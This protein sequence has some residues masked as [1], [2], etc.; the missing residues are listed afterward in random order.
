MAC[1][2]L[3]SVATLID[4]DPGIIERL[5]VPKRSLIVNVPI[6]M[7]SGA[8]PGNL[9]FTRKD[10]VEDKAVLMERSRE[11][12]AKGKQGLYEEYVSR[13]RKV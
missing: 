7:D 3:M 12:E 11:L 5:A 13:Y 4:C 10:F 1:K 6:R 9:G 8:H 2:Q